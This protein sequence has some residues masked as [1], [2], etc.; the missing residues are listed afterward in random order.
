MESKGAISPVWVI[1]GIAVFALI[2]CTIAV[3]QAFFAPKPGPAP[4][5]IFTTVRMSAL[6]EITREVVPGIKVELVGPMTITKV[7]TDLDGVVEF[8]YL[9][10]GTY[11][12]TVSGENYYTSRVTKEL[13]GTEPVLVVQPFTLKPA[14]VG[15]DFTTTTGW[16]VS[17]ENST[18]GPTITVSVPEKTILVGPVLD[19]VN[20]AESELRVLS[21]SV[22]SGQ[23]LT[24]VEENHWTIALGPE[25]RENVTVSLSIK[26][27]SCDKSIG[28]DLVF[29]ITLRDTPVLPERDNNLVPDVTKTVELVRVVA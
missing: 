13:K 3:Y 2:L 18:S 12:I 22:T 4:V 14:A 17:R 28:D 15:A 19:L 26:V 5:T 20:T 1:V 24:K 9:P 25:I 10:S 21:I 7:D 8:D 27:D 6:N 29:D 23:L 16:A 11:T